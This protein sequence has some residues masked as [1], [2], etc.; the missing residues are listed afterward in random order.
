[1]A[2]RAEIVKFC[3]FY[4]PERKTVGLSVHGGATQAKVAAIGPSS[5]RPRGDVPLST[6]YCVP[7]STRLGNCGQSTTCGNNVGGADF[8]ASRQERRTADCALALRT[9]YEETRYP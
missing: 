7:G 3:G 2:L 9:S 4:A 8:E 6:S 5:E 1:M